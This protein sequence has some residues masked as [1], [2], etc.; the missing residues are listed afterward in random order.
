MF[1]APWKCTILCCLLANCCGI[2]YCNVFIGQ[3][4]QND[5]NSFERCALSGPQKHITKDSDG[6]HNHS[7][8][9]TMLWQTH[10]TVKHPVKILTDSEGCV[11]E[12]VQSVVNVSIPLDFGAIPRDEMHLLWL[13]IKDKPMKSDQINFRFCFT[14]DVDQLQFL[15]I[16]YLL[17]SAILS[18][19][20]WDA[21]LFLLVF[22]GIWK[23]W[24]LFLFFYIESQ[25]IKC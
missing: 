25:L 15:K 16:Y 2:N 18:R 23:W 1:K 14:C 9:L 10:F 12:R 24:N 8:Q 19:L 3:Y 7:T 4:N 21:N 13:L 6:F 5:R 17:L 20:M 22:C 11:S